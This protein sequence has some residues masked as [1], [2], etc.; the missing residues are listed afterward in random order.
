MKS[1]I[2]LQKEEQELVKRVGS[3]INLPAD[4]QLVEDVDF[5]I[6]VGKDKAPVGE[7]VEQEETSE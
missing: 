3:N 4:E 7:S 2:S 5:M 1:Q 6:I